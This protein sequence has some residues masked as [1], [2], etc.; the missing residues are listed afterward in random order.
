M[1]ELG[2]ILYFSDKE[3]AHFWEIEGTKKVSAH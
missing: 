3:T 1:I 2:N